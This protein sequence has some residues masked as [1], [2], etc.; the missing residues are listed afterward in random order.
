MIGWVGKAETMETVSPHLYADSD[1]GGCVRTQRSTSGVYLVM[2]GLHNSF[3]IE[4][5]S[6][7]Q[8]YVSVSTPEAETA[9]CNFA[10]RTSGLLSMI[11]WEKIMH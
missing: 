6:K 8:P 9:A 10:I 5:I 3:P 2:K 11:I 1:L 7:R 4:A